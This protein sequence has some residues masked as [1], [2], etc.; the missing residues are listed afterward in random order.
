LTELRLSGVEK[1]YGDIKVLH[2][3]DLEIESREFVVFVGPSG[4][5]KSTLLRSIAGLES[6]TQGQI[7]IGSRDVTYLEPADRGV[8]MVFQSYALYPH[9]SVYDNIAFGLKMQKLPKAEIEAK[10][11]NAAR[12]LQLEALLDRKPK[13]LSGGQRQRVAIGRAIVHEPEVFLFDEPLSNL[14]A[15]LRVQMRIEIAKLHNDLQA[16]MIYVTHDQVEAMTLADKI[17]VLN[18]GRIE[19]VGSPLE[20]YHH[21][22]NR[23]VAGFIGSPQMSFVPVTVV[24]VGAEGV[25]ISLP[26]GEQ[27]LVPVHAEGITVG[28]PLTLGLRPEHLSELGHGEA[29]ILAKT[30]VVE[31]LGGET[32]SHAQTADGH[33][34]MVKGA[35]HSQV[36][37][38]QN[39]VIGV[40]GAGCHLFDEQ[41]C[42]LVHLT[43][44]SDVEHPTFPDGDLAIEQQI[45]SL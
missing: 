26:G 22:R 45:S 41:G 40:T 33:H 5:G 15:S 10:V 24:A 25:R 17:V 13:A 4:C 18:K 37:S 11:R 39:L 21:P 27:L 43:H 30:L 9:M 23:F 7:R 3:I 19:Q 38:G 29:R 34:I 1:A 28:V 42:A 6:I 8:A 14:D 2:N 20:L 44:Y 12:I 16:T 32:F 36:K 35:G 31:H